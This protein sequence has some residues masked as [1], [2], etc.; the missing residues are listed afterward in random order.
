M[1]GTGSKTVPK[2]LISG[3]MIARSLLQFTADLSERQPD[4]NCLYNC[5]SDIPGSN[6][7]GASVE[8]T[9]SQTL[10]RQVRVW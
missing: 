10:T 7:G 5:K 9:L 4:G 1:V 3:A 2:S 8:T 6:P